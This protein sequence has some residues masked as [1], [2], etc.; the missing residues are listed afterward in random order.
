MAVLSIYGYL[1]TIRVFDS[2]KVILCLQGFF[3]GGGIGN[4]LTE[5]LWFISY[6][7]LC[8]LLTPCLQSIINRF[9]VTQFISIGVILIFVINII[10]CIFRLPHFM[11]WFVGGVSYC[12]SYYIGTQWHPI[13]CIFE[14]KALSICFQHILYIVTAFSKQKIFG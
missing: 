4:I 3:N 12:I 5:H 13:F 11:V 9:T 14:E 8:Y 1:G 2:L 7:L 6:I 10:M